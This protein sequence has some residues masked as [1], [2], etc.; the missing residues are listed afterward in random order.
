MGYGPQG[1]EELDTTEATA[2]HAHTHTRLELYVTYATLF[3]K[4]LTALGFFELLSFSQGN[5]LCLVGEHANTG[6]YIKNKIYYKKGGMKISIAEKCIFS[7]KLP[8]S[9][10]CN[11]KA[12]MGNGYTNRHI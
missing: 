8:N 10:F 4:V 1:F 5:H 11:I 12:N 7:F 9:S 2:G 3:I 6:F